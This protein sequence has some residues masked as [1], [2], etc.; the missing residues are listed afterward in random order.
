MLTSDVNEE[1]DKRIRDR[2]VRIC[3]E[4]G[5]AESDMKSSW[6]N[7]Y[8]ARNDY[9]LDVSRYKHCCDEFR[10]YGQFLFKHQ[11][12]RAIK[13][14]GCARLCMRYW[15]KNQCRAFR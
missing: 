8:A 3:D 7:Y 6:D 12:F 10:F 9:T 4:L 14:I 1:T 5:I 13:Y 2:L 11:F 15:H